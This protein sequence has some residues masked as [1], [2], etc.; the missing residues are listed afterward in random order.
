M[1]FYEW[2]IKNWIENDVN[3]L[4][5]L[6]GDFFPYEH[7][8]AFTIQNNNDELPLFSLSCSLARSFHLNTCKIEAS[9][10][11]KATNNATDVMK[12]QNAMPI[13]HNEVNKIAEI[14]VK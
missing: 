12:K 9:L 6:F 1:K 7:V 3:Q 8:S 14:A 13:F 4:I 5:S 11:I 2:R 10:Q